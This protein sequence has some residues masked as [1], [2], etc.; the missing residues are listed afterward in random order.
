MLCAETLAGIADPLFPAL[1]AAR[2]RSN[3]ECARAAFS[4]LLEPLESPSGS[5]A[6]PTWLLPHQTDAVV[7]ARSILRR[8]GGVLIADGVGL[9][10]TWIAIA[11]ALL[12]RH[13]GGN[14]VAFVPA[15]LV[16]E[17]HRAADAA[18][19]PL[20]IH[21]HAGLS[22]RTPAAPARCTLVI[23]DEAH[24]FRNPRTRRY[25]GLARFSTGRRLALLS[26]TPL[27]NTPADLAALVQL[28]AGRDRFREFG[29]A[30]LT[31]ALQRRDP[32]ATFALGALSVCRTRRLVEARF[33]ELRAAF[34]RR[35]LCPP[36]P[37]DLAACYDGEL[38]PILNSLQALAGSGGDRR[39]VELLHLSLLRRL[40]SSRAA[41]RRSLTRH[42][43]VLDEIARAAEQG[44]TLSRAEVRAVMGPRGDESQMM[45]WPLLAGGGGTAAGDWLSGARDTVERALALTDNAADRPDAKAEALEALLDGPL[46]GSKAIVFTEHRD[47]AFYLL[48]RLRS[49][50]RVLAVVGDTAWASSGALSRAEAL[51]AFAPV[52]R[53]AP[54]RPLLAADVLIATDVASEGLNL[55][56]ARGVVNYDLPWNPVRVMQRVGR[57]DRL[58]SPWTDIQIAHLVPAAGLDE[59]SAVLRVLRAKL[60]ATSHAIGAEPDPLAALWW[61]DSEA[62]HVASLE[63]ESWRR[64][65]PF[66]ARERWRA[67]AGSPG[68]R[69][70][71]PLIAAATD[72]DGP[73]GV[74][75][76][77]AIEWVGGRRIPLPFVVE[78]GT[79]PRR[80]PEALGEL[81]ERLL[82]GQ[83][84]HTDAA[85]FTGVLAT[86]LPA[87]RAWLVE[88]SAARRGAVEPGMGRRAAL[89]RLERAGTEAHRLRRDG[90]A[91]ARAMDLLR[92]DLPAGLD[93]LIARLARETGASAEFA[94]R[95]V[96]LVEETTPPAAPTLEG[97]P[98]LVLVAA[99]LIANNCPSG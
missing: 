42:R 95:I 71:T 44:V 81:A 7:R 38:G 9:G 39:G 77:M 43:D 33:P 8:F 49:A 2:V 69:N 15:A 24:A 3:D 12:E 82:R 13:A 58:H 68:R 97:T 18:G 55:Q 73:P 96:E 86:V 21:T 84:V 45:M 40:E 51:D 79:S 89:D 22:R 90:R 85:A 64:V 99:F 65:A 31:A 32:A 52:G 53:G 29:V 92:G 63:R 78:A 50:R 87:A 25:D 76:L 61:L 56:D 14:A 94:A 1:A 72:N 10:K 5:D 27:N 93:R 47:T 35:I 48:R 20:V 23:V 88:L 34:P 11:L 83:P 17:W 30:D 98:R 62:P 74:G 37:Y 66:E 70:A 16:A 4:A 19:V 91:I 36:V 28:F 75:V 46:S 80:D 54:S 41:L 26:A 59:L 6:L 57:I 60:E 67:L